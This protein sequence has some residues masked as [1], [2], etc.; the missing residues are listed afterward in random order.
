MQEQNFYS[1]PSGKI[2]I[3]GQTIYC[4]FYSQKWFAHKRRKD[5]AETKKASDPLLSFKRSKT[6]TERIIKCNAWEWFGDDGQTFL[7]V[8][9][10]LTFKENIQNLN[11][12]NRE[13]SKFIQRLNYEVHGEKKAKLQYLGVVEFQNRGAIH[14]HIIFF[15]LPFIQNVYDIWGNGMVDLK[16]VKTMRGLTRYLSKY[17]V[18]GGEVGRL[19]G[20]KRYFTSKKVLRPVVIKDYFI[21][22]D[23]FDNLEKRLEYKKSFKI[24]F[25]GDIDFYIYLLQNKERILDFDLDHQS[26]MAIE[27]EINR[28]REK[29]KL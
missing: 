28:E 2:I 7:P 20:R 25:I 17:M 13:F 22:K 21:A 11:I 6:N 16:G 10:T 27:S 4:Y 12:A 23:I 29:T 3:C 5:R 26:R 14:Y 15:N 19:K 8:F 24:D 1:Y 9:L 18:K